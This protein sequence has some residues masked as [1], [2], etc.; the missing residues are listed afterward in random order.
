VGGGRV[1]EVRALVA[2]SWRRSL[3]AGVDPSG[4]RLAPVAA[5]RSEAS[6][7]WEEHPLREAAALIR[8]CLAS[9][10]DESEH[11]IVLSDADGVL[12]QL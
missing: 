11:L 9:I 8:D 4:R 6:A 10:A 1:G 2:D 7:R 3:D 12:L 5:D